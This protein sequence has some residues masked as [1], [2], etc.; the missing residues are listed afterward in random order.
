MSIPDQ[1]VPPAVTGVVVGDDGSGR[2]FEAIEYAA[3]EAARRGTTLTVVRSWNIK[4]AV[5]PSDVGAGVVPSTQEFQDATE[6]HTRAR[7][8]AV[9]KS[10]GVPVQAMA[11]HGS[12]AKTLLALSR[13]ADVVVVGDRGVTGLAGRIIGSVADT[14][15]REAECP[16]VVVRRRQDG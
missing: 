8:E 14:V 9:A 1:A 15:V 7:A 4:N 5:R 3:A 12:P 2:A 6:A 16:V 13:T 11:L 10:F